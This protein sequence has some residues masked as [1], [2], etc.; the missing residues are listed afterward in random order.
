MYAFDYLVWTSLF[1]GES[2][3]QVR[4]HAFLDASPS[5]EP[6][7][8]TPECLAETLWLDWF[9]EGERATFCEMIEDDMDALFPV[10][11]DVI[12]HSIARTLMWKGGMLRR[13]A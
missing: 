13:T 4:S 8:I 3:S 12:V 2:P 6:E 9:A 7:D 10:D 5:T 1:P 11:D